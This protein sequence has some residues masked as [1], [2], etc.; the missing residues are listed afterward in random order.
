MFISK[1]NFMKALFFVLKGL[2]IIIFPLVLIV[3]AS[4]IVIKTPFIYEYDYWKYD[5]SEKTNLDIRT[6]REVGK[7]IRD[8]FDNDSEY[9]LIETT[10]NNEINSLYNKREIEHMKDVKGLI[11]LIENTGLILGVFLII[12]PIFLLFVSSEW[13]K[14]LLLLILL[15]GVFSILIIILILILFLFFFDYLFILFHEISFSNDLWILNPEKDYLIMMFPENFFRDAA[16]A[17]GLVSIIE[18]LLVY[19]ISKYFLDIKIR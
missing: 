10:I 13:K 18:F 1:L 5:I 12:F 19:F 17:I 14:Q 2:F 4:D 16:Y 3:I 8:Y 11:S 7:T 9:L 15:S 6:L